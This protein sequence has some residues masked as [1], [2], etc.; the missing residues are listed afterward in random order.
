MRH[1]LFA[2]SVLAIASAAASANIVQLTFEGVGDNAPIGNFYDGGAGGNLGVTFSSNALALVDFDAGGSGNF[3]GEPSPSTVLFF[4]TGSAATLNY[5]GGFDTGFSFFYSAIELPGFV[6]VY[7]GLNSTGAI[8]TQFTLP[9]TPATGAPDPNGLYSPFVPIGV[10]FAGTAKSVDFGGAQDRI[11]F[12]DIT[13]GTANPVVPEPTT[14][15]VGALV[16]AGL[17]S[18]SRRRAAVAR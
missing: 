2:S 7:D 9:L 10:T 15:A 1:I 3:G 17:L 13:F 16:S 5:A 11:A 12:D 6:T 14:F 18:R 8:L 4:V